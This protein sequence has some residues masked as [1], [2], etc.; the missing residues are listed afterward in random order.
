MHK[1]Y[2]YLCFN[3]PYKHNKSGLL[4]RDFLYYMIDVLY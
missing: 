1:K 2:M 3:I 4:F